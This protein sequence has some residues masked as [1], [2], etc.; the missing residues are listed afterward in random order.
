MG[1]KESSGEIIGSME[2]MGAIKVDDDA[3]VDLGRDI[4]ADL[5][6]LFH[7]EHLLAF[8]LQTIG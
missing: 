2:D 4:A 7:D 3:I 8:L 6:A 1:V 5:S